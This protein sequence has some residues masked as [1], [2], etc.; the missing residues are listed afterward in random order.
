MGLSFTTRTVILG[1]G[2]SRAV[3]YAAAMPT[4]S[5]LDSDF[6]ELVQRFEPKGGPDAKA[7]D[8]VKR[9]A[10]S[11]PN[12][13]LWTSLER[14][15]YTSHLNAVLRDKLIRGRWGRLYA[16]D[17]LKNFRRAI[18]ALLRAAHGKEECGRH[19]RLFRSLGGQDAILTFNYDLVA[20]RALRRHP[21]IVDFGEWIYDFDSVPAP[22]RQFPFLH[23]LHGSVN[24]RSDAT[25]RTPVLRQRKWADFDRAPGY[26]DFGPK[27]SILLPYWEKRVEEE[28]WLSIW[29]KAARHLERTTSLLIWGYSCPL[30]DLKA[31]ELIRI[32]LLSAR[33]SLR[34]VCVIDP[35]AEVR[36]R[37]RAFFVKQKF[38][39]YTNID[40]FLADIPPWYAD[41]A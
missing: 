19:I 2:A 37:W 27:F 20:E 39:Q 36:G 7:V 8:Y 31:R 26:T 14:L 28:P 18:Q 29:R 12:E 38:W 30:T 15:F 35:S 41:D 5:P 16:E 24:W 9:A 3:T 32:T 11:R 22:G 40:E 4:L 21:Q 25:A 34:E 10:L 23:K 6:F 17:L 1:A 13:Q 33:A